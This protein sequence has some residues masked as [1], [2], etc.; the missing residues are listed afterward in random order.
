MT[1]AE[2]IEDEWFQIDYRPSMGADH[3]KNISLDDVNVAFDGMR[4]RT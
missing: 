4:V 3:E 1:L 2:I